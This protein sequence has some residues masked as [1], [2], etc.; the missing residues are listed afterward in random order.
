[1]ANCTT[2]CCHFQQFY[3]RC[4]VKVYVPI[5]RW[6]HCALRKC[7]PVYTVQSCIYIIFS[8]SLHLSP[9]LNLT[10]HFFDFLDLKNF[11]R[12]KNFFSIYSTKNFFKSSQF[13][14][15]LK[16]SFIFNL[17]SDEKNYIFNFSIYSKIFNCPNYIIL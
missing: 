10:P 13:F 16:T 4:N 15:K 1:M 2:Q 6:S 12:P 17:Q 5:I 11:Y 14:T 7:E 3:N 9:F 8:L